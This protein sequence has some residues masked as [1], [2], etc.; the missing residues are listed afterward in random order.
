MEENND[1]ILEEGR[2][3][4]PINIACDERIDNIYKIGNWLEVFYTIKKGKMKERFIQQM[5]NSEYSEFF[6][7]LNYEF[8][9]NGYK[10]DL[11]E[12]FK[13][14]KNAS[15]N[16]TDTLA[17]FRMYHIYKK[18]FKKFDI[19]QRE[20]IP[21]LFYLFKC[22]SYSRYPIMQRNQNLFNKFDIRLEVLIHF[23]EEDNDKE[24]FHKF[25]MHLKEHYYL[26]YLFK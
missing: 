18:D 13:I 22:F 19:N 9:I 26:Y 1:N 4:Y 21:E 16:T 12:A 17:M 23:N 3:I 25:I 11:K 24:K 5:K 20:R 8:G 6:R 10:K 7:G 15:N 14:Y 2:K